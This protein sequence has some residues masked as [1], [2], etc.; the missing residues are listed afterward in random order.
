VVRGVL[1]EYVDS[2]LA[3]HLRSPRAIEVRA[4]AD[5]PGV[6]YLSY[7]VSDQC[8][9][10]IPLATND[11]TA[12]DAIVADMERLRTR[13]A[14]SDKQLSHLVDGVMAG[15]EYELR[16]SPEARA[17]HL[18][19]KLELEAQRAAAQQTLRALEVAVG[20]GA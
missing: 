4:L 18:A 1:A 12:R 15:A 2:H 11:G 10:S 14:K 9:V 6:G 16:A 8:I 20:V 3:H 13:I 19:R 5:A 7:P 17:Q